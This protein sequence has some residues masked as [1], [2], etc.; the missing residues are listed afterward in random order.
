MQGYNPYK[1]TFRSMICKWFLSV[2]MREDNSRARIEFPSPGLTVALALVMMVT[3]A[4]VI[5]R[6]QRRLRPVYHIQ[7]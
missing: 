1:S 6:Q 3:V 2:L 7:H 5:V 4:A